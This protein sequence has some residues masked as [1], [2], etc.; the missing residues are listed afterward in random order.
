MQVKYKKI[1][2]IKFYKE[3][4]IYDVE[5]PK[6]HNYLSDGFI[7]HNSGK[8]WITSIFFS[9]RGYKLLCKKNPQAFF[10]LP[11]GEPI[12]FLNVAVSAD[13]AKDVFFNK[14]INMVKLA[15]PKAFKQFGFSPEKDILDSKIIFPK[16]IRLFSG[17][18]EMDSMEGKN[19]YAAVMDEA[20]AFKTEQELRGKGPRAKRS[21]TA[22]YKFLS[23]SIRSRF[24]Q[25][26]KLILIS[27]PRFKKDFILQRYEAGKK[28]P[29]TYTSFGATWEINPL[30]KRED[31]AKDYR[32]NP[33]QA[34]SMYECL[35]P[36]AEDPFIRQQEYIDKIIDYSMRRPRDIWGSYFPDFRGKPY[37]YSIG[38]D[39][40][41]TSDRTG[42]A[43]CHKEIV[44][45][46]ERV[47]YDL[48]KKW[49]AE[50][51]KEIDLEEVKQEVLFLRSRGFNITSVYLDQ[52]QSAHIKQQL[53]S[54]GFDVNILSIESKIEYWN[55][56]KT[57]IYNEE[58]KTCD[59]EDAHLLV[60]ELKGLSLLNGMKVDHKGDTTKDLSDAVVRALYGITQKVKSETMWRPM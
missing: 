7:D 33:E 11:E 36:E 12:D 10:G 17:H 42:F 52:Y 3:D 25:V 43:M 47:I 32:D 39:L 5:V 48:L 34:K 40:S 23:S 54:Q 45:G 49:E 15:G 6:N 30:R 22:I 41:L 56:L 4:N 16:N 19:L 21:A 53:I 55:S 37:E 57:L 44:N 2:S 59:S 9:R 24:P 8:D 1:K 35:P 26:G 58:I 13:Q 14:L 51:G 38:I 50:Q 60:N 31:F 20:A 46:K 28:D 18:S 29:Q 27:Y